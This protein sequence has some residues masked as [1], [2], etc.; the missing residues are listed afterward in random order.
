M[1]FST[2]HEIFMKSVIEKGIAPSFQGAP[3]SKRE[4]EWLVSRGTR[5]DHPRY[6]AFA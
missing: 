1:L 5:Q 2:F 6:G 4:R 3:L